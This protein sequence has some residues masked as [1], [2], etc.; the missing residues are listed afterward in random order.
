MIHCKC[1]QIRNNFRKALL[2]TLAYIRFS[3]DPKYRFRMEEFNLEARVCKTGHPLDDILV[4]LYL[5]SQLSRS[6]QW[7]SLVPCDHRS[8]PHVCIYNWPSTHLAGHQTSLLCVYWMTSV[9]CSATFCLQHS[10]R[11]KRAMCSSQPIIPMK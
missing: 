11:N 1:T 5:H 2:L 6:L 8:S 4:V 3:V 9:T 10:N 7:H